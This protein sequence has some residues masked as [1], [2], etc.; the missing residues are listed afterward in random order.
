M[1]T[2]QILKDQAGIPTGVFI[3]MQ[4]WENVKRRYPDIEEL[5]ADIPQWEKDF[6]D[7][8]L[9]IALHNP[10]RLKPVEELFEML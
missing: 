7:A 8:R 10:N 4:I 1:A 2:I 9:E 3:P 5:E 6:I